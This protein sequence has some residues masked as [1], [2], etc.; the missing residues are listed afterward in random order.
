MTVPFRMMG[1]RDRW[2]SVDRPAGSGGKRRD[3]FRTPESYVHWERGL[4]IV[5]GMVGVVLLF[6]LLMIALPIRGRDGGE[7]ITGTAGIVAPAASAPPSARATPSAPPAV[8]PV[9]PRL[10]ASTREF[11]FVRRGPGI[12]FAVIMNLRQGQRVEVVGK[13]VDRQWLQI[14]VPER[15]TERGWVSQEFLAVEGDVNT[16]RDVRE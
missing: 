7:T 13:S 9:E 16:L 11:P 10:P 1:E 14:V 2:M 4:A 15:P 6:F 8:G 3:R 5:A 12:N